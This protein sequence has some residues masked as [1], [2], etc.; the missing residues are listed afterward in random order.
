MS[1]DYAPKRVTLLLSM[2]KND[3]RA[4]GCER[5]W[6]CVCE[7][8]GNPAA[9]PFH[10]AVD[11]K[12]HIDK[13]FPLESECPGFPLFPTATGEAVTSEAMLMF[14]EE[15]ATMCDE[16]LFTKAGQRKFGKHSWRA[17]GAVHLSLIGLDTF[18]IQLIGRWLCA[19]VLRYCRLAPISDVAR[20]YVVAT[21]AKKANE[22][23]KNTVALNKKLA[24]MVENVMTKYT[25]ESKELYNLIKEVEKQ[26]A[27]RQYVINRRTNKV[28]KVLT[29]LQDVGR[30][31]IA[32][33]GF[34]YACASVILK[35]ELPAAKRDHYCS[36]CLAEV[37]AAMAK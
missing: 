4:L 27:P 7:G 2:S 32:Y 26:C 25:E 21:N 33:C 15:L 35:T 6:G 28:H 9:C 23:L 19:I 24:N 1:I 5:I 13:N 18:K 20:D 17:S 36:T 10:A 30:D 22:T 16:A 11:I 31:A 8:D 29:L 34:K 3:P 37:R 12:E 14:I